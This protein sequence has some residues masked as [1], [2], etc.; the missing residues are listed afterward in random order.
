M[1]TNPVESRIPAYELHFTNITAR[2]GPGKIGCSKVFR[3]YDK[4]NR[5]RKKDTAPD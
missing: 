5:V 3:F 4:V 1:L 2:P